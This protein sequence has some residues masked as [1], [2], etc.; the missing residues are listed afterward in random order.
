MSMLP[1]LFEVK[2]M[3]PLSGEAE[4]GRAEVRISTTVETTDSTLMPAL[5]PIAIPAIREAK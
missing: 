4:A 5:D 2:A 3:G 1:S